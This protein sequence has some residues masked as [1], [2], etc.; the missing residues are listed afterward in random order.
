MTN[1]VSVIIP[2]FNAEQWLTESIDSCLKQTYSNIEIIVVDD[3]STDGSLDI[4]KGYGDC[5]RWYSRPNKGSN[6]TRNEGLSMA[7]GDYVLFLDA[8]D[9]ILPERVEKQMGCFEQTGADV[10]FSSVRSQKHYPDGRIVLGNPSDERYY[11]AGDDVLESLITSKR[12]AHNLSPMF[13]RDSLKK[14]GGWDET[15][16]CSQDR[17]LLLSLALAGA[18]FEFLP[19]CYSVYRQYP[20][21][22]RVSASKGRIRAEA[23]LKRTSKAEQSL[24]RQGRYEPYRKALAQAL[25]RSAFLYG[26]YYSKREY[27]QILNKIQTLNPHYRSEFSFRGHSHKGF[28]TLENLFGFR[29]ASILYRWLKEGT[30]SIRRW[31]EIDRVSHRPLAHPQ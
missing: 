25:F 4:I 14:V 8:D 7:R 30:Q 9:Y 3:G 1:Q 19:G 29:S 18:K 6:P 21:N 13:T 31:K 23:S 27:Q 11:R 12:L 2:C 5:L 15:V 16:P 24:Q 17:D 20:S 22:S 10:V 28:R 26:P